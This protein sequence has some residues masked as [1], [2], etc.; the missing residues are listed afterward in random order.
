LS[1]LLTAHAS[2]R[3]R[4]V[5]ATGAA[6]QLGEVVK[7]LGTFDGVARDLLESPFPLELDVRGIP[8]GNYQLAVE[9]LDAAASLGT[10]TLNVALRQ[11]LD[12][13]VTRLEFA[14]KTAPEAVRA[15]ILFPVD[16]MRNVNR[17]RL[18]ARTFNP[19]RDFS[20]AESVVSAVAGGGDPYAHRTG[21]FKRHYLLESANEILPYRMYVPSAYTGAKPFPLIVA[22]HG[23]G[24][25][26]DSFFDNYDKRLRCMDWVARRTRFS[27]ITTSGCR[28]SP[29]SMATLSPPRSAIASMVRTGGDSARR[30]PIRTPAARRSSASRT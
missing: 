24:G 28:R 26:E 30:R 11:G 23:L 17:G 13:L 18:E 22:L 1:R 10:A 4:P 7:D 21:D 19:I 25:T 27:T 15:D 8:D 29:N 12:D 14:A 9:V 6:R 16:R 3:T 5:L 2:L 20:D